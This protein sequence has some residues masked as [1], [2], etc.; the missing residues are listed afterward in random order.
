[1]KGFS[2]VTAGAWVGSLAWDLLHAVGAAEKKNVLGH[3]S[4]NTHT[5]SFPPQFIL[6][7]LTQ[8]LLCAKIRYLEVILDSLTSS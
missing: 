5:T 6:Q 3:F 1:M 8:Y 4:L 2:T 7:R